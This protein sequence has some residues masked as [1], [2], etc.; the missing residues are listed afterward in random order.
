[1][2]LGSRPSATKLRAPDRPPRGL[3][4]SVRELW[5]RGAMHLSEAAVEDLSTLIRQFY[6]ASTCLYQ[7]GSGWKESS[8]NNMATNHHDGQASFHILTPIGGPV[9]CAQG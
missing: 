2:S 5:V 9:Q 1:M 3:E 6:R 7:A 8:L 4:V